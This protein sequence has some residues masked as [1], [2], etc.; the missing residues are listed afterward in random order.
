VDCC[1]LLLL[2]GGNIEGTSRVFLPAVL[3]TAAQGQSGMSEKG[4]SISRLRTSHQ[5]RG[6]DAFSLTIAAAS[7][8]LVNTED[9]ETRS[10]PKA[11]RSDSTLRQRQ[12][13][14]PGRPPCSMFPSLHLRRSQPD[15]PN[16]EID[17]SFE[18]RK[19]TL[20]IGLST[21]SSSKNRTVTGGVLPEV[22]TIC[23]FCCAAAKDSVKATSQPV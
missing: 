23:S 19:K 1:T 16:A 7:G 2:Q 21:Q 3:C 11:S 5:R 17:T 4:G 15:L 14:F 8:A 22:F 9:A 6:S 20:S 13:L 10:R 18:R 12:R